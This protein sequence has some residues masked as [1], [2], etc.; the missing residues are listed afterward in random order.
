M[1]S[2]KLA[3]LPGVTEQLHPSLLPFTCSGILQAIQSSLAVLGYEDAGQV[4]P[5]FVS[6][7][8]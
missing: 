6:F 5:S 8:I 3:K 2:L 4:H 7:K 1:A